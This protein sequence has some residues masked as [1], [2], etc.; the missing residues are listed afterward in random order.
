VSLLT[1]YLLVRMLGPLAAACLLFCGLIWTLQALRLGHHILGA[2]LGAGLLVDLLLLSLPSLLTFSLPLAVAFAVLYTLLRLGS[3]SELLAM[4]SFGA[5]PLQLALPSALLSLAA[6]VLT[7]LVAALEAPTLLTLERT[8]TRGAAQALVTGTRPRKFHRLVGHT[9]Y[10]EELRADPADPRRRIR[11]V[12]L[13]LAQQ[14]PPAVLLARS[15]RVWI[16]GDSIA[17]L[18]LKDAELQM[19]NQRGGLRRVRFGR[20]EKRI[21]LG[22]TLRSHLGFLASYATKARR[23]RALTAPAACLALG[24]LATAIGLSGGRRMRLAAL[25]LGAVAAFQL[26]SWGLD[27]LWPG[28]WGG[29]VLSLG[30]VAGCVGWLT[31]RCRRR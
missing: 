20:L 21:D 26:G 11:Y 4:R 10:V 15:A 17:V 1:R 9:L 29:L 24:L 16:E 12:N 31:R 5:S 18:E 19:L 23:H 3:S 25:G 6:L 27:L 14:K 2:G 13:L 8:L 7:G 28:P 22:R 30:V